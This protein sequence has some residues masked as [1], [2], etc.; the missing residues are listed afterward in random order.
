MEGHD[1]GQSTVTI[2]ARVHK[3]I[4]SQ[5]VS[6]ADIRKALCLAKDIV[7]CPHL[8]HPC[9]EVTSR[10]LEKY[11]KTFL[12]VKVPE[13]AILFFK[14]GQTRSKHMVQCLTEDCETSCWLVKEEDTQDVY[15][16]VKRHWDYDV[17]REGVG[18]AVE[19]FYRAYYDGGFKVSGGRIGDRFR[20]LFPSYVTTSAT[21]RNEESW[22]T[23]RRTAN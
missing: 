15:L 9:G 1:L 19:A 11:E 7:I 17:D 16:H 20:D 23:C 8:K 13:D 6:C 12:G 21:A 2:S 3:H 18:W 5:K 14:G 22:V 4:Q 10:L